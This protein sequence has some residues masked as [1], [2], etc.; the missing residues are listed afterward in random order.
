[1]NF[2]SSRI[3]KV[4]ELCGNENQGYV[5][6]P[7]SQKIR[8]KMQIKENTKKKEKKIKNKLKVDKLLFLLLQTHFIYFKS[9]I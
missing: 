8:G 3:F 2:Q 9:L 1:M 6:F 5:W 4:P 7:T